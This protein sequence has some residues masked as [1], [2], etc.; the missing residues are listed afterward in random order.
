[1]NLSFVPVFIIWGGIIMYLNLQGFLRKKSF[2][3]AINLTICLILFMIH[4]CLRNTLPNWSF[5]IICDLVLLSISIGLFLYIN[6]IETRR[7]VI[8]EV[9]ENR[10]KNKDNIKK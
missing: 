1:V 9:F 2:F 5:S 10:Y 3:N 6:D 8:S 7:K 4:M